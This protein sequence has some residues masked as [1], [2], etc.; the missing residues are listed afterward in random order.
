MNQIRDFFIG[1]DPGKTGAAVAISPDLLSVHD[2]SSPA[3]ALKWAKSIQ[4]KGLV[5]LAM[6]EDINPNSMP[7]ANGRYSAFGV[8]LS[9]GFWI[10]LC[11]ALDIE[12]KMV[13]P[14]TWQRAMID[15]AFRN[16]KNPKHKSLRSAKQLDLALVKV[17]TRVKDHNRADAALMAFYG[18][19]IHKIEKRTK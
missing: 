4:E 2:W 16:L 15:P 6:I 10:M 19:K 17:L 1:I 3:E 12:F 5:R 18:A 8:G 13:K 14:R 11:T 9:T 7:A